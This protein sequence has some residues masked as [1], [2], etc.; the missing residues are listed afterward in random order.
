[1]K[2][3]SYVIN[4]IFRLDDINFEDEVLHPFNKLYDKKRQKIHDFYKELI[5]IP[6]FES[7][8]PKFMHHSMC[9]TVEAVNHLFEFFKK[10]INKF[11]TSKQSIIV[12][13]NE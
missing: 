10:N 13:T 6:K 4:K 5:E 8:K 1:M 11:T 2:L 9:L 3:M 12:L 7:E